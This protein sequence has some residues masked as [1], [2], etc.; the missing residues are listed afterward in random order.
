MVRLYDS[1]RGHRGEGFGMVCVDQVLE[2]V[3]ARAPP[4][5][6][7]VHGVGRAAPWLPSQLQSTEPPPAKDWQRIFMA[8]DDPGTTEASVGLVGWQA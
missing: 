6:S 2:I 7:H 5:A 4:N 1:V 8:E 3:E